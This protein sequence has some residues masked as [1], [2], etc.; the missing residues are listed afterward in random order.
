MRLHMQSTA[1]DHMSSPMLTP[2]AGRGGGG[3]SGRALPV[4]LNPAT[5][6]GAWRSMFKFS[7]GSGR[8]GIP[9]TFPR[10]RACCSRSP[11]CLLLKLLT[12][13]RSSLPSSGQPPVRSRRASSSTNFSRSATLSSPTCGGCGVLLVM[14]VSA[15][16]DLKRAKRLL[17]SLG[18]PARMLSCGDLALAMIFW[19]AFFRVPAAFLSCSL[20]RT[21][22]TSSGRRLTC[23]FMSSLVPPSSVPDIDVKKRPTLS[24]APSN[25]HVNETSSDLSAAAR[26]ASERSSADRFSGN[27]IKGPSRGSTPASYK[28]YPRAF[29]LKQY[30]SPP[31][32]VSRLISETP[33]GSCASKRSTRTQREPM[34]LCPACCS[35]D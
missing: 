19:V 4:L 25:F 24:A 18:N 7:V 22:K 5:G 34:W 23:G 13:C 32:A 6:C 30:N 35:R 33:M 3:S 27:V 1:H 12:S 17:I 31:E 9:V 29:R 15:S 11:E 20:C 8:S 21:S 16:E 14:V 2:F 10:T 28:P 26:C